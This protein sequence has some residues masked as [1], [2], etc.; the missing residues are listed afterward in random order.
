MSYKTE[1]EYQQSAQQF[2]G[3]F[4]NMNEG[5]ALHELLFNNNGIAED[6]LITATNPAFEKIL[7][8]SHDAVVGKTSKEAYDVETPPFF[9][10][11]SKVALTGKKEI[12]ETYFPP[13]EKHFV[14]SVY[15]THKNGFATVFEDVTER[16]KTLSVLKE[17]ELQYRTLADSGLALIWKAGTD[18][19]CN[20]F[21]LPWL[22]FTGRTFE[23][24]SGNGWA[25]GV[26][27]DDFD[28]CLDTYVNAFDKRE[29]FQMEYRLRH[30][31]GEYRWLLDKGTPNYNAEGEFVGYIGH[32]FDITEQKKAEEKLRNIKQQY[33]NLVSNIPV[34]VYILKTN[35]SY[36]FKL[37]FVSPKMAEILGISVESLLE[38]NDAIYKAIHPDDLAGFIRLNVEGIPL[39]RP[40]NW[41]GRII[42]KGEIRWMNITSKPQQLV[43]GDVIWHGLIIDITDRVRDEA[44][45]KLKNEELQKTVVEKDKFFSI[46]A[47]D[48]KSPF[49]SFLGYTEMMVDE[50]DNMS[51]K[52]IQAMAVNMKKTAKN[53]Y[54][55][56]ENLLH[57]SRLKLGKFSF[58]P[59]LFIMKPKIDES[60]EQVIE[61]AGDKALKISTNIPDDLQIFADPDMLCSIV[62]NLVFNAVKFT[63]HGGEVTISAKTTTTNQVEI[64]VADTGIGMST[65]LVRNLFKLD[66]KTSRKGTDGE[67]STGLGLIICKDFI[68]KHGGNIW[69]ESV[70]GKGSTFFFTIPMEK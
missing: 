3:L 1:E 23:Q 19:L 46:I 28:R 11:Y 20:Y 66:E 49:N 17:K 43:S 10:I 62:R 39:K 15:C 69:V 59:V 22:N 36:D 33:E 26:H 12:F 61:P 9:D 27:P 35:T 67:P 55:L 38:K 47:H 41:K 52:E 13:L 30:Y 29:V 44:E 21:N 70:E 60:L 48:L 5:V 34:G 40:F 24:E 25:E 53:L 6:Y 37:E 45:I 51:L 7:G 18:K 54:S 63:P 57:W 8:I 2:L 58:S 32:C 16:K 14:I 68:E 64:S 4:N 31:S 42:V 50:L 56:L 65:E